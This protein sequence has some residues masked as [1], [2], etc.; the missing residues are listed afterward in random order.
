MAGF[1]TFREIISFMT[2]RI[3][4]AT[5]S[6][7]AFAASS[8]LANALTNASDIWSDHPFKSIPNCSLAKS[9]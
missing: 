9:S 7:K 2:L 6:S 3:I 8:P 4:S 1:M 5:V